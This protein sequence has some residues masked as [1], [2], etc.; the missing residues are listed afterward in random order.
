ML[1]L[2]THCVFVGFSVQAH[3]KFPPL[4]I[5]TFT[6]GALVNETLYIAVT[7]PLLFEPLPKV[8][9]NPFPPWF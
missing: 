3:I 2:R 6:M 7:E 9:P 5:D 1:A 8:I 4:D